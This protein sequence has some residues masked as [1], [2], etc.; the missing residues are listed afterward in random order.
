MERRGR[1]IGGERGWRDAMFSAR[2]EAFGTSGCRTCRPASLR[3]RRVSDSSREFTDNYLRGRTSCFHP[4][5]LL[6]CSLQH[7]PPAARVVAD[8]DAS[9]AGKDKKTNKNKTTQKQKAGTVKPV[10]PYGARCL[11]SDCYTL[12]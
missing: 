2:Q 1:L 5:L 10:L 7:T 9:V 8:A 12:H 6:Q 4:A 11:I 3:H